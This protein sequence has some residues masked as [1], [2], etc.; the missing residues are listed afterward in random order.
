[1]TVQWPFPFSRPEDHVVKPLVLDDNNLK[2]VESI[3]NSWIRETANDDLH[4][5]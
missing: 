2:E 3:V 1:M 4:V 5:D